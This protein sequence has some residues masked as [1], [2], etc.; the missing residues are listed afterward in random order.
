MT[1]QVNKK[2]YRPTYDVYVHPTAGVG[3]YTSIATALSTEGAN[4][5]IYVSRGTYSESENV[6][7]LEGQNVHFEPGTIIDFGANAVVFGTSGTPFSYAGQTATFAAGDTKI[8]TSADISGSI[9]DTYDIFFSGRLCDITNVSGVNLTIAVGDR[10][11]DAVGSQPFVISKFV[12]N[13]TLS[14]E[15]TINKDIGTIISFGQAYNLNAKNLKLRQ[16]DAF[17]DGGL[18]ACAI[19]NVVSSSFGELILDKVTDASAFG[20]GVNLGDSLDNKF[21]IVRINDVEGA[22]NGKAFNVQANSSYNNI[23]AIIRLSKG[24]SGTGVGISYD[25]YNG[26]VWVGNRIT[27]S[28][29]DLEDGNDTGGGGNSITQIDTP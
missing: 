23:N 26:G 2:V 29:S 3:D 8:V 11:N 22:T 16:T 6:Y 14:G 28:S 5:S 9:D 24:S 1:I 27:V 12:K 4:K 19:A 13:I 25:S 18:V 20:I 21:D 7:F 17:G 10:F 15:V